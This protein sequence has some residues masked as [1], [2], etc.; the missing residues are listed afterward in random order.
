LDSSRAWDDY[1]LLTTL[2]PCAMYHGA[3]TQASVG[4]VLFAAA[5]PYAGTASHHFDTPQAVHRALEPHGPLD[6]E[7]GALAGLLAAC[8]QLGLGLRHVI[9]VCEQALPDLIRYATAALLDG[10]CELR[11][12]VLP[13][14]VGQQQVGRVGV[15][16]AAR[17]PD[18]AGPSAVRSW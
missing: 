3:A 10:A 12:G 13:L 7:R 6:G 11:P 17:H 4:G 2:E 8:F 14:F 1:W 15:P 16:V 5:D 18:S 9:A